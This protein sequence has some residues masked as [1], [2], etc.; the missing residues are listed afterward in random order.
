MENYIGFL[1]RHNALTF[2]ETAGNEYQ[3]RLAPYM[4]AQE[5]R[6]IGRFKSWPEGSVV[7]VKGTAG[8][9]AKGTVI[10]VADITRNFTL[11][12]LFTQATVDERL[13]DLY[14]YDPKHSGPEALKAF[15]QKIT[16]SGEDDLPFTD[17]M[18]YLGLHV[19]LL[20]AIANQKGMEFFGKP[21]S[22]DILE[23]EHYFERNGYFSKNGELQPMLRSHDEH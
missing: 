18:D 16:A 10:H 3:L 7:S 13:A 22:Q 9:Q 12:D 11:D 5:D 2:L 19:K 14:N 21:G 23:I 8:V 15:V 1:K 6:L 20:A 4:G 17:L